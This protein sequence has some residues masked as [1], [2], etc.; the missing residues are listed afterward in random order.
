M[1]EL[2]KIALK[3]IVTH[4]NTSLEIQPGFTIIRGDNGAGKSLLFNCIPNVFDGAV[5]L[6]KKKDAKAIHTAD[7]SAIGIKYKYNNKLY[8]V[9]QKNKKG[10]LSYDIEEDGTQ[11]QPRTL[12]MAKE[13]L[14][15]VFPIS[16]AQYYT[17]IHL[18]TYRPHVLLSGTGPQRKEFFEELFHLNI[19]DFILDKAKEKLNEL[20]RLKDEQDLLKS[21]LEEIT[22]IENISELE[23]KYQKATDKYNSLN[24]QYLEFNTNIQ[25]LTSI[26]TYKKQ[27]TTSFSKIE[28]EGKI[29][30]YKNAIEKFE[31]EI[32]NLLV[33]KDLYN[34]NQD[35][36][37]KKKDLEEKLKDFSSLEGDS[38]SVK[39]LYQ[40]EK[41]NLQKEN[42]ELEES[43]SK[44]QKFHKLQELDSF[45]RPECREMSFEKYLGHIGQVELSIQEKEGI[46][47]RLE[48]LDGE[49]TCPTCQQPLDEDLVKQMIGTLNN[50]ILYLGME[51]QLKEKTIEWYKLKLLNLEE[52]DI[53]KL[54]ENI[55][56]IKDT[57]RS[58][59]DRFEKLSEKENLELQLKALPEIVDIQNPNEEEL[60]KLKEKVNTGKNKLKILEADLKIQNE[61]KKIYDENI[62]NL[63][64]QQLTTSVE[65]LAPK[66][67]KLN[68][69]RMDLNSKIQLGTSQNDVYTKRKKRIEDIDILLKELPIYDALT[70]AYGA[71]GIRVDQIKFLAEAFCSN[72]NKFSN[73]VFT[74]KVKFSVNVDSTNFNIYA[75]RNGGLVADVNTFS[76]AESRC[77]C[78]LCLISLLPFI[79]E[80]Y[81]SDFVILDEMEAGIQESGRVLL[82]QGFFKLLN[83]I[84]PKVI[85]ITP[86]SPQ[87]FYIE[88]NK[89]YYLRL[90]D[91]VT[92]VNE[93]K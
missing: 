57:L 69:I 31:N 11:L 14:E 72:L 48:K 85:V 67:E 74:K 61:L 54:E 43:K 35:L 6:A 16:T 25:K 86:M 53:Q 5:P 23:E 38:S 82:T 68:S 62:E 30:K 73:L 10:S 80:K 13:M 3:N 2:E 32:T 91:N 77:F 27:L 39:E 41:L 20:K 75:E 58:L 63:D 1:I 19:S 78:L 51:T 34:K 76:G 9:V 46:I 88:S 87:E 15:K 56:S 81:R 8:R 49:K 66:I 52:I 7:E 24:K 28:L 79:P 93:I 47:E 92:E 12:A 42:Q 29:E 89:E 71:K 44:N 60:E 33:Q 64:L 22:Y 55:E 83:E 70:K 37:K 84:V 18:T 50:D 40:K 65:Q 26:D 4:K 17:L 45:I 90:K 59:K 36:I 21:Q